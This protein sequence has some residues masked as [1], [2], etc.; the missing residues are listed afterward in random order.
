MDLTKASGALKGEGCRSVFSGGWLWLCWGS[1]VKPLC[2]AH[3][4]SVRWTGRGGPSRQVLSSGKRVERTARA[5]P[6]PGTAATFCRASLRS[7]ACHRWASQ[8]RR[9][10]DGDRAASFA[11]AACGAGWGRHG[12]SAACRVLS[13]ASRG[14]CSGALGYVTILS[15][16]VLGSLGG[17]LSC[18]PWTE[19]HPHQRNPGVRHAGSGGPS[20]TGLQPGCA[21][22]PSPF[23]PPKPWLSPSCL[24]LRSS[25]WWPV[26][27][28]LQVCVRLAGM[29]PPA[30]AWPPAG[31][32]SSGLSVSAS[33][34]LAGP[35]LL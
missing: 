7:L 31:A 35:W 11:L 26:A 27:A 30:A 12:R 23:K 17:F 3:E 2:P 1:R 29:P 33:S 18:A 9:P 20:G 6:P 5:F 24:V 8:R 21:L 13:G 22:H 25:V 14:G 15:L 34:A 28:G 32:L 10:P 19:R 16:P 4:A